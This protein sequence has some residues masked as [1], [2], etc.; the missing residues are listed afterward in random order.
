MEGL[1]VRHPISRDVISV[2][3]GLSF[4]KQSSRLAMRSQRRHPSVTHEII[5]RVNVDSSIVT[6]AGTA[7]LDIE[8]DAPRQEIAGQRPPHIR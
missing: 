4:L 3:A 7:G 6:V 8:L 2:R 1:E 5:M